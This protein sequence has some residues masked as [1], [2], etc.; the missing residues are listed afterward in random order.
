MNH[1]KI[2][3][4]LCLK[5]VNILVKCDTDLPL[6]HGMTKAYLRDMMLPLSLS[7]TG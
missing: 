1:S 5:Y 3:L 7:T 6:I 2:L 4:R